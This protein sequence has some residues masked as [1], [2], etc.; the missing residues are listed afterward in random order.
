MEVQDGG[1]AGKGAGI[2]K[3]APTD[4]SFCLSKYFELWA[5]VGGPGLVRDSPWGSRREEVGHL[6]SSLEAAVTE[7]PGRGSHV[8]FDLTD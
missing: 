5:C 7:F 4:T 1:P 8:G 6:R 2:L 3:K